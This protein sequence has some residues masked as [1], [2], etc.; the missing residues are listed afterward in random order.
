MM[1]MLNIVILLLVTQY[2]IDKN[3]LISKNIYAQVKCK[4]GLNLE[5]RMYYLL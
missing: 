1:S 2:R 4:R 5:T 3:Y